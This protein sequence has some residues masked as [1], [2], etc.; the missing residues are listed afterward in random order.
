MKVK[1][2]GPKT[3]EKMLPQLKFPEGATPAVETTET[4]PAKK[5]A[6]KK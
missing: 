4:A 5:S 6:A 2:I 3:L 1:G